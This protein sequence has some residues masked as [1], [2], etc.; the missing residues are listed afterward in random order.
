[1]AEILQVGKSRKLS[2]YLGIVARGFAMGSA[3]VVPGVS[4]GTIAFILGIYE[5]LIESIKA[6]AS[7]GAIRLVLTFKW[8]EALRVLPWQFLAAVGAGIFIAVLTLARGLEWLL[9][10]QAVYLWAFFFGLVLASVFVVSKQVH[11]WDATTIGGLVIATIAAYM[12]V[13]LV[14]LQTPN[15]WWFLILS[16]ALAVCA[17]ILP[18]ISG[19]FILVLLGKYQYILGAVNNRD[20]VTIILVGLGAVI[21]VSSFAQV[22]SFLFR[23]YH[24]ATVAVLTGLILGSLRKIWPWKET[25]QT[26]IDRHGELIPVLQKNVLPEAFGTETII[27]IVLAVTGFA[28]V[29]GLDYHANRDNSAV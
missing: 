17:L 22:V 15:A 6:I 28:L 9:E 26:I 27:A 3:D 18:G 29:F 25:L 23:R 21:G 7:P 10:N 4:G 13:G 12:L 1:M 20:F 5:E 11:R 19:A 16:G 8:G 2:D 14:P 24:N